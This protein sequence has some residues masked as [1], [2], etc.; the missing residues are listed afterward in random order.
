MT[1]L[2]AWIDRQIAYK[3]ELNEKYR[4]LAGNEPTLYDGR[5]LWGSGYIEALSDVLKQLDKEGDDNPTP[6]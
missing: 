1:E 2:K 6:D 4:E 3:H 5:I